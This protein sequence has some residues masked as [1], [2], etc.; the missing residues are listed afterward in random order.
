MSPRLLM[1]ALALTG[2]GINPPA[3]A[4]EAAS[5]TS[6][7][8]GARISSVP[9]WTVSPNITA[10]RWVAS[11]ESVESVAA[12]T[13]SAV[14]RAASTPGVTAPAWAATPST[15]AP[16]ITAQRWAVGAATPDLAA[17]DTSVPT[18]STQNVTPPHWTAAP[19]TAAPSINAQR[20]SAAPGSAAPS[21]TAPGTSTPGFT[22]NTIAPG[23]TPSIIAPGSTPS[24]T[25]P[26]SAAQSTT[27]PGPRPADAKPTVRHRVTATEAPRHLI[28]NGKGRATLFLNESTG[29]TAAS[30]TLLE[31]QPGG[32]VPEHTHESSAEILYIEDGAADMTVSGQTLRVSKG[33]AVYIPA[34]A[35]HSAR[36]VS[37]GVPFKAVQVYAGP[38]PEQRFMQGPRESAPHGR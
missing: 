9:E 8:T 37:P 28:A 13:T 4:S 12:T 27:A 15:A 24:T 11:P 33:D 17:S 21:T 35:K 36:V 32:E 6:A 26:G 16:S 5:E 31:L 14:G 10:R 18:S 34:G 38:G 20:W 30:L 19:R 3:W 25:A 7:M 2:L 29:A 22:P 1:S 23:S